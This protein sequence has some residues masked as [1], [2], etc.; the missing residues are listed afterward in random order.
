[1]FP[2][3]ITESSKLLILGTLPPDDRSWYYE[4]DEL[5]WKILE[6]AT[7]KNS[8]NTEESRKQFLE[9]NK[10]ALWDVL[11][12]GER[13]K[14]NK[15][16]DSFTN[17]IPNDIWENLQNIEVIITNGYSKAFKWLKKG[18]KNDFKEIKSEGYWIWNNK[19]K[20]YPLYSTS[21]IRNKG[22][23][24]LR[25]E[26]QEEWKNKWIET[27]RKSLNLTENKPDGPRAF[28]VKKNK[29]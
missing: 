5:M 1:M 7:G 20:V 26:E 11:K 16:S 27:I 18:K 22:R 3:T 23:G 9:R 29:M 6:T 21:Y 24:K 25:P 28:I 13:K 4:E 12:Y 17:R 15:S 8:G 2:A 10:I 14:G 19:I